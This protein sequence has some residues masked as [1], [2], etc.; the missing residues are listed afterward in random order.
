MVFCTEFLDGGGLE[1]RCV[2]RVCG[3]DRALRRTAPSA[4]YIDNSCS[5]L[6]YFILHCFVLFCSSQKFKED[7]RLTIG[8][9]ISLCCLQ[10]FIS[11]ETI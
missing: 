1:S 6:C 2:G 9:R 4:P 5:I 8:I 11:L 3:A 10:S 7:Q